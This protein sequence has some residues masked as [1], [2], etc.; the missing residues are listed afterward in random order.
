MNKFLG[1]FAVAASTFAAPA[2]ANNCQNW[3]NC[4]EWSMCDGRFTVG[5]DWLYWKTQTDHSL[6]TEVSFEEFTGYEQGEASYGRSKNLN[7]QYDS[8]FRV[9]AAYELPCDCWDVGVSYVYLPSSAK[10]NS[11]TSDDP[12]SDN[13]SVFVTD[14]TT[15]QQITGDFPQQQEFD[16]YAAK[17]TSNI[18]WIDVD[19]GRTICLGECF[20]LRPHAGFRAAWM[21]QSV[22]TAAAILNEGENE[23]TLFVSRIKQKFSGYGVQG[24]I[25]GD[26]EI[27]CGLSIA[28][29]FGGSLLASKFRINEQS[30]T[31]VE[32][33]PTAFYPAQGRDSF[34]TATPTVDYF[35]GLRYEDC[36]CDMVFSAHIGWESHLFFNLDR[37]N[38]CSGNLSTQGLTL[39]LDVGF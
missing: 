8:G 22:R 38:G 4:C 16:A 17:W 15:L 13:G 31:I 5:A 2:A 18:N 19:L 37:L 21:D 36:L 9:Y 28:G 25:W 33:D 10:T 27:G 20:K 29:H 34:W 6:G 14:I 3:N 26:W 32:G 12:F 24:G 7:F 39:G 1:V 35:L 30:V 11:F 23:D